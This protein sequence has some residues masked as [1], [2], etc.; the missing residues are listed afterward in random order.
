[1]TLESLPQTKSPIRWLLPALVAT[2]SAYIA[3]PYFSMWQL[4]S[5]LQSKNADALSGQ[6]D[7]P[8]LRTSLKDQINAFVMAKM[9]GNQE[10]QGNILAG[11]TVAVLPKIVD[12]MVDA[13]VTP[14]GVTQLFKADGFN[15]ESQ[16]PKSQTS[17]SELDPSKTIK[18]A[19][20][21]NPS[22]FLLKTENVDFVF[23]LRDWTW[24]LTEVKL[25]E[26]ALTQMEAKKE[27]SESDQV[28]E[29]QTDAPLTTEASSVDEE[30][31]ISL[32]EELYHLLSEKQFDAASALYTPQLAE[33]FSSKFFNQFDRVTVEDLRITSRTD[34]SINFLGQNTYVYPD[35]STQ[36]ESR[37]YTVRRLGGELK[38]TSSEFIKVTGHRQSTQAGSSQ[39]EQNSPSL[40]K[41]QLVQAKDGYANLRSQPSTEVNS[42]KQI[43]NGTTVSILDQ[44]T[45]NAKQLWYKVEVNGQVGWIYSELLN[46]HP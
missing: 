40:A 22:Q 42:L 32:V 43:P 23:R 13:Y 25:T 27:A 28:V 15:S 2:I 21:S 20:F 26:S 31:A 44:Q 3:W 10:M 14:A 33:F 24:K 17:A 30:E 37:S 6:I 19:F 7:F 4:Y 1:M 35:G 9:A 36:R 18:F 46:N 38:L 34:S 5:A 41:S 45:N 8:S 16:S 11:L 12:S 29:Q 39:T